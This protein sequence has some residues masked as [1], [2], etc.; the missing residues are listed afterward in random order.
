[1]ELARVD[2]NKVDQN[3]HK[4]QR[5]LEGQGNVMVKANWA[6]VYPH[7]QSLFY[8]DFEAELTYYVEHY[9]QHAAAA[10][11]G[12]DNIPYF[13]VDCGRISCLMGIAYGCE[14][15][16]GEW[17]VPC[18]YLITD[19]IQRVWE[20]QKPTNIHERG[21]YP[22][23]TRR[24]LAIRRR[25]GEVPFVPSDVQSPID[26]ATLVVNTSL[27]LASTYE[28]PDA[29]HHLLG[30]LTESIAEIVEFQRSIA[31]NWLGSGHD[32]PLPRGI[33]LS[34]DNAAFLSPGIY[35]QFARPYN[36]MLSDRF[37]GVTLHC[38]MGHRQNIA[39]MSETRGL[40]GFDPQIAYNPIE[41]IL[42]A[43]ARVP[44]WRIWDFSNSPD[45][46]GTCQMLID[47]TAGRCGLLLDVYA[48]TQS[49][50][51]RLAARVK[52][53]ALQSGRG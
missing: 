46:L 40:L 44:F 43:A 10:A 25:F 32:Y 27:L 41:T 34:D 7:N 15:L 28:A 24:M 35:R 13:R 21:L 19:D 22:E 39:P 42:D 53:Y 47:R 50:A 9:N 36:E 4:M 2:Q 3:I 20:I 16:F 49:E 17:S 29:V 11:A 14:P 12:L 37:G 48:T 6:Q 45:V 26:A 38:C 30:M 5:L 23:L 51:L 18:R 52:E 1:M 31:G 33:H 8:Q